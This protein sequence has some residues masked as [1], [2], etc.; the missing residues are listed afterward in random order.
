MFSISYQLW[1]L[2]IKGTECHHGIGG[3]LRRENQ[4]RE[5]LL[6]YS[7]QRVLDSAGAAGEEIGAHSHTSIVAYIRNLS[8]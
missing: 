5:Y 3:E 7:G 8:R 2:F 4:H 1:H 6:F